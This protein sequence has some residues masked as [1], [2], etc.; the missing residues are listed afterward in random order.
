MVSLFFK[1]D[2]RKLNREKI[3]ISTNAVVK[4]GWL[5]ANECSGALPQII[6]KKSQYNTTQYDKMKITQN[7][8]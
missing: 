1:S 4:I 7:W 3:V 5:H 2:K 8:S 6:Y